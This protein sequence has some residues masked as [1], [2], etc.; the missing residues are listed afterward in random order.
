MNDAEEDIANCA[1]HDQVADEGFVEAAEEL[2]RLL[3]A[4]EAGDAQS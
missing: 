2:F 1:P 4:D 3:D